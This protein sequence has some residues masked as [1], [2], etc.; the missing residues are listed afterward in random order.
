MMAALVVSMLLVA[1]ETIAAEPLEDAIAAEERGDHSTAFRLLKKLADEGNPK[2]Q[3]ELGTHFHYG[4]A[5]RQNDVE[6]AK[7]WRLSAEQ[8]Y[9]NAQDALGFAYYR[10]QGVPQNYAEAVKW[11]ERAADQGIANSAN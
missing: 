10:G 1:A 7:W 9:A 2:A 5:T 3:N 6:A 8:G 11:L 4:W